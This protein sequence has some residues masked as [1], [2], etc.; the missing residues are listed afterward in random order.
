MRGLGLGSEFENLWRAMARKQRFRFGFSVRVIRRA[1]ACP[2]GQRW[3]LANSFAAV[4]SVGA[5]GRIW[6]GVAASRDLVPREKTRGEFPAR[7]L[8]FLR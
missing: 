2:Q 1:P 4:A 7:A 5:L 6:S 3:R 8:E